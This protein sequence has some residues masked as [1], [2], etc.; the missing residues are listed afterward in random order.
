MTPDPQH[1]HTSLLLTL[2]HPASPKHVSFLYVALED[3]F[4]Y[5]EPP[6]AS[7]PLRLHNFVRMRSTRRSKKDVVASVSPDTSLTEEQNM[8]LKSARS[9]AIIAEEEDD[10]E[11]NNHLSSQIENQ[12]SLKS[13]PSTPVK[14]NPNVPTVTP[15]KP[16]EQKSAKPPRKG[17]FGRKVT[18]IDCAVAK[19]AVDVPNL[20]KIV[21]RCH[22]NTGIYYTE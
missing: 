8:S 21:Y 11:E 15:Q 1:S 4:V 10:D 17:P 7:Q 12:E 18:E 13:K 14:K 2:L 22:F 3:A 5:C 20:V 19:A 16:E 6:K 9:V